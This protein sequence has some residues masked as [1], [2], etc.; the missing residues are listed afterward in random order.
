MLFVFALLCS[1]I[2]FSS[3]DI[4]DNDVFTDYLE[5]RQNIIDAEQSAAFGSKIILSDRE[6]LANKILTKYK[7]EE[8]ERAFDDSAIFPPS[9]NFLRVSGDIEQ[10][11]VYRTIR[12]MPKGGVLH[13]HILAISSRD[14][15]LE[16]V[17]RRSNLYM[18]RHWSSLQLKFFDEKGAANQSD[19]NWELLARARTRDK[20][21]DN[22][23]AEALSMYYVAEKDVDDTWQK[24]SSIFHFVKSLITYR[25]VYEDFL[26]HTMEELYDDNVQ[27]MEIRT[28]FTTLY[29]LDGYQ[30]NYLRVAEI[31]NKVVERFMKRH[32]DFLGAKWIY[33]PRRSI[34][35][36]T[37]VEHI[38]RFRNLKR[39]HP[40]R[41]VGFDLVGQEDKG[42]PLLHF[43]E[44]LL[45]LR[46]ETN[47]YF[48]AGETNWSGQETDENLID[49]VLLNAKRIGH[50][51]TLIKHPKLM[52]MIRRR[53]V[54]IEICP[55]SNQV[56]KLVRD[57]RN[58]PASFFFAENMPVVV[59]NDDPGFWGAR[60]LSHDFYEAFVGIMSSRADLRA[61]KQLAI[62]SISYSSLN[63]SERKFV[64]RVW[65]R[66][67]RDFIS[68]VVS[69][70]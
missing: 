13:A 45:D 65:E 40:D 48:H 3:C 22:E 36:L 47:F 5:E 60:A 14:F 63:D 56:L 42:P 70:G 44:E 30:H 16:N 39:M 62:N 54:G 29:E 66:R 24:F 64:L 33:S 55:I 11:K 49:A 21:I 58:H 50:G 23:I 12:K 46:N 20:S 38:E 57:L 52:E 1:L 41:I 34:R 53:D 28:S 32:P 17:T 68:D 15:I 6:R 4:S 37:F 8:L 59:S 10:S 25:P 7:H 43:A 69:H 31:D 51:Y 67:W 18:C 19:C 9:K 26:Y 35:R 2:H 61:L 27:F